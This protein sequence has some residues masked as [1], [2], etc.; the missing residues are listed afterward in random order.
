MKTLS[1]LLGFLGRSGAKTSRIEEGDTQL[2][3]PGTLLPIV[4]IPFPCFTI[5]DAPLPGGFNRPVNSWMYSQEFLFNIAASPVIAE[6]GPGLWRVQVWHDLIEA[7]AVSDA[8]ST[9]RLDLI[10][11]LTSK[12]ITLTKITNK[13]NL[14]QNLTRDF[15]ILVTADSIFSFSRT[16][17]AGLGTGL[18]LSNL[19]ILCTRYF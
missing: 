9:N 4:E 14:D 3:I 6:L 19:R 2:A 12:F 8:T 7:G 5:F 13:Q 18:N 11:N 10:D 16:S 15:W 17:A 1:P